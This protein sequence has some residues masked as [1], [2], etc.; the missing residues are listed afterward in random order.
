MLGAGGQKNTPPYTQR[1]SKHVTFDRQL[2]E[3]EEESFQIHDSEDNIPIT[4]FTSPN[5]T[6]WRQM[7]ISNAGVAGRRPSQLILQ[8]GSG[9]TAYSKR[10]ISDDPLSSWLVLFNKTML[11]QLNKFQLF[12]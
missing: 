10:N 3:V 7:E 8:E 11:L 1:M 4:S 5:S 9:L 6:I 2:E 12:I